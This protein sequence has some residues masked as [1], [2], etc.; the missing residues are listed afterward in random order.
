MRLILLLGALA[1]SACSLTT[2]DVQDCESHSECRD[3][4]GFGSVCSDEGFCAATEVPARCQRTMPSDLFSEP[5]LYRDAVVLGSVYD[6]R[7]FDLEVQA[8]DLA[9]FQ[10]NDDGGLA[11][12]P[13]AMV[14]CTNHEDQALDDLSQSEAN[15][16]VA[17]YLLDDLGVPALVGPATSANAE[18]AFIEARPFEAMVISPSATSVFLT[19][20][21]NVAPTDEAPGLLWR[22]VPPDSLQ[23][24]AISSDMASRGVVNVAVIYRPDSYG[25]GLADSFVSGWRAAGGEAARFSFDSASGLSESVVDVGNAG[26]D[27]VLFIS[28]DKGEVSDFL[29]AAGSLESYDEVGVF[30]TDGAYDEDI[31]A[32]VSQE[33]AGRLFDRVRGSRPSVPSGEVYDAFLAAYAAY[34]SG[35]DASASGFTAAAYDASWLAL[36]GAAWSLAS[37]G[38]LSGVGMARGLRRVSAGDEVPIRASSWSQVINAFGAG[39][40]IDITGASGAL[41][42]DP[43]TEETSGPFDIWTVDPSGSGFQLL[44]IYEP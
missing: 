24:L 20:I 5:E 40:G 41:D 14:H 31:L 28:S 21:D 44:Y 8:I 11:G 4:F 39:E 10:A 6:E 13:V 37:E 36:Y 16:E 18:G 30:L 17:R 43:A 42:Y 34:Y 38:G 23:S 7:A 22:T 12:A 9:L 3:A 19:E 32:D 27:E 29:N 25:L 15:A 1:P 33:A 26:F 35:Q 2:L